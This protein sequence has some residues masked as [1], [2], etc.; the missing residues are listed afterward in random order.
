MSVAESGAGQRLLRALERGAGWCEALSRRPDPWTLLGGDPLAELGRPLNLGG[1]LLQQLLDRLSGEGPVPPTGGSRPAPG[2]RAAGSGGGP[3]PITPVPSLTPS[4]LSSPPP[5]VRHPVFAPPDRRATA[6]SKVERPDT[7]TLSRLLQQ[8]RNA[9]P[10]DRRSAAPT[11]PFAKPHRLASPR[12]AALR[13]DR[14]LET[15]AASV[16]GGGRAAATP[17]ARPAQPGSVDLPRPAAPALRSPGSGRQPATGSGRPE[18][19]PSVPPPSRMVETRTGGA[20]EADPTRDPPASPAPSRLQGGLRD[21][22]AWWQERAGG[23]ANGSARPREPDAGASRAAPPVQP[24]PG[25][26]RGAGS[27]EG[28]A[29]ES[30]QGG[31]VT[32]PGQF[33]QGSVLCPAHRGGGRTRGQEAQAPAPPGQKPSDLTAPAAPQEAAGVRPAGA[34]GASL[35]LEQLV[36]RSLEALLVREA[37]R[38]GLDLEGS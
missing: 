19:S 13:P 37:R 21:L 9:V 25:P 8:A 38:H 20:D 32:G 5:R 17:V 12:P 26:G 6:P 33:E 4:R 1:P 10:P 22:V 16:I 28:P 31:E 14:G 35:G 18:V 7:R 2:S 15:F 3:G 30:R 29:T 34:P 24:L 11:A 36:E 23:E 27:R